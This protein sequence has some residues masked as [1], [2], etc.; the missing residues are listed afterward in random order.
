MITNTYVVNPFSISEVKVIALKGDKGDTGDVSLAQLQ[1]EASIRASADTAIN[2]RIDAIE[3]TEGLRRY[4]VSGIG[5]SASAL[6]RLWDSVGMTAQVGTDGDNSN[7]VNNF[8]DATPFNRR[9]CVGNWSLV[10]GRP[11]FHV[12]AYYGDEDYTEDG[13]NGDFVA[14][15]CPRAYYYF[16]NG[17]LGI[18]AHQWQGWRPFDIFCR[19]HDPQNTI[20]FAY[21]PAYALALKDGHAVSLPGL[22]NRQG[23]YKSLTDDCRTYNN[24]VGTK[25]HLQPMAV[26]FYE[27]ALFTVEFATQNCQSIMYGCGSL[28]HNA[29]DRATL[30][31]DGKWLLSN[32][33]AA[34]VVGEYISLQDASVDINSHTYYASHKITSLTR[35]DADGNASSSGS[36]QLMETEDLGVGRTY[37]VGTAYRIAARPYRTGACNSVSTPSGSPVNNTNGYFPMKYRWRENVYS[38]QYKTIADLFNKRVG[39]GDSDYSLE[40]YYLLDPSAYE[41][42]A[43]SKPDATDL[44]TDAFVLLDVETAHANYVNGYIKSK[45]YSEEY[46]DLWI[47]FETSGGSAS[48]YYCDYAYLVSSYVVRACRLGGSWYNGAYDGFSYLYGNAAPSNA[49]AY[50]GGDLFFPQ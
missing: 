7:V 23:T 13:T 44:A 31:S 43:A 50:Y 11:V 4:G 25:A 28:R 16:K 29:D 46:P 47:P 32:Y 1:E 21:L 30:R 42:S 9:K 18:S 38:N 19:D 24:A 5:Q 22:D 48:T 14:V 3:E 15:E 26:N 33:N 17:V 36:Y 6:T 20:P 37:A 45:K 34:R 8:D 2:A 10:D 39:T 41:P 35:C 12:H 40:W 27:W 49:N